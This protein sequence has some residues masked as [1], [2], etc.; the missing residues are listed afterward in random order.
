[1]AAHGILSIEE[2]FLPGAGENQTPAPLPDATLRFVKKTMEKSMQHLIAKDT[3]ALIVF[4]KLQNK[5]Q[6]EK[7]VSLF[8]KLIHFLG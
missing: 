7:N 6:P 8:W 3:H 1:M 2:K 4:I 5:V